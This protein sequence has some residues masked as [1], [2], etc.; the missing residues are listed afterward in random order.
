MENPV[1]QYRDLN[2][3]IIAEFRANNGHVSSAG[4]GSNLILMHTLGAKTGRERI[5]PAMSLTDGAAWF[6]VAAARGAQ[7]DP[8]WMLNLRAHPD[9]DIEAATPGGVETVPV[10]ATELAGDEREAVYKRFAQQSP[11]F[12]MYER[13]VT[14]RVIPVVRL[15]RRTEAA[16]SR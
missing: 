16:A 12:T 11:T 3:R 8:A 9:I 6:V 13:T 7:K 15:D 2:E 10:T 4:F 5:R 1:D 14:E